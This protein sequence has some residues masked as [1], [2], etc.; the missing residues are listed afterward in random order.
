NM[1][2]M[3]HSVRQWSA[4]IGIVLCLGLSTWSPAEDE[5]PFYLIRG[6][7]PKGMK[8]PEPK[9]A[10][11]PRPE[12]DPVPKKEPSA[13]K[14]PDFK[15]PFSGWK[16]PEFKNP[17]SGWGS[18]IDDPFDDDTATWNFEVGTRMTYFSLSDDS[19]DSFLGSINKLEGETSYNPF[20]VFAQVTFKKYFGA[21]LSWD[22]MEAETR[23]R[24]GKSDGTLDMSGPILMLNARYPNRTAFT[25]YA[26]IGL[27]FMSSDFSETHHWRL[28]YPNVALWRAAGS[29]TTDDRTF[30]GRTRE[31]NVDDDTGVVLYLGC[32]WNF[33]P[34]WSVDVFIR[35][36]DVTA[37]AEF[38]GFQDGE[39]VRMIPGKFP[40]KNTAFGLGIRHHF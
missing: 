5:L 23:T 28:G 19:S 14:M 22:K 7:E 15:N 39:P 36:I 29:P 26:G 10:P 31:M 35:S 37:E 21:E 27:A 17:F 30:M 33:H 24:D 38:V 20:K 6:K 40:M 18:S 1:N 11:P 3:K 8:K 13:P 32:F 25:P 16:M 9:P 2:S 34:D 12:I 4:R